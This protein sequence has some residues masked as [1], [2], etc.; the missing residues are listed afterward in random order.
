MTDRFTWEFKQEQLRKHIS[1]GSMDNMLQWSTMQ[2]SFFVGDTGAMRNKLAELEPRMLRAIEDPGVGNPSL[3]AGTRTSGTYV[4]QAFALQMWEQWAEQEIQKMTRIFEFGG[5]YGVMPV[6]CNRLGFNGQYTIYDFPIVNKM[7]RWYL[8]QAGVRNVKCLS[9]VGAGSYDL[10][11][12]LCG[13]SEAPADTR[14]AILN[15]YQAI[16]YLIIFQH[17]WDETDN[18][19]WFEN[20]FNDNNFYYTIVRSPYHDG[21]F[22]FI[23]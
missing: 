11:I 7:Q 15:A 6:V 9:E 4:R 22:Y 19:V 3:M 2:E 23:C 21:Q 10:F 18:M 12:S 17:E 14:L 20:W 16:H 8:R 5:G 1:K 13:L